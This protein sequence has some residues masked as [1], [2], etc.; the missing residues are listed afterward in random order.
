[1]LDLIT[2]TEIADVGFGS[3][4]LCAKS[5]LLT[6]WPKVSLILT[7]RIRFRVFRLM[8]VDWVN[9]G[10]KNIYKGEEKLKRILN[11]ILTKLHRQFVR[12]KV[13]KV[14]VLCLYTDQ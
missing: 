5:Y 13:C 4:T 7:S 9:F 12:V 6:Y 2:K 10:E 1:M 3:D 11:L 8:W 14:R